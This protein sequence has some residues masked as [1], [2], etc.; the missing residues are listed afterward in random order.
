MIEDHRNHG[1]DL[2]KH[3]QFAKITGFDGE[4]F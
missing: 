1:D 2:R 4:T 3:F